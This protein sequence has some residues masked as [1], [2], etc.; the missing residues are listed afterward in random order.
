[1]EPDGTD[2]HTDTQT[3]QLIDSTG[4]GACWLMST[5][6]IECQCN[7]CAI[8]VLPPVCRIFVFLLKTNVQKITN[9]VLVGYLWLIPW[10]QAYFKQLSGAMCALH[11]KYNCVNIGALVLVFRTNDELSVPPF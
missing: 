7:L 5:A 6:G 10:T 3:T 11:S 1:M 2:N 4:Q 8:F 9:N